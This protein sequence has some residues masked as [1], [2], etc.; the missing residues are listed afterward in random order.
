ML[1]MIFC[2]MIVWLYGFCCMINSTVF[3]W[4]VSCRLPLLLAAPS[5]HRARPTASF[6]T[7]I[8]N[9]RNGD[10]LMIT[11]CKNLR[12]ERAMRWETAAALSEKRSVSWK[13]P[14]H[15]S[16]E[17]TMKGETQKM[18]D[19][20]TVMMKTPDGVGRQARLSRRVPLVQ[21]QHVGR[22]VASSHRSRARFQAQDT[23]KVGLHRPDC[24]RIS[25][26]VRPGARC[27]G[28]RPCVGST[29][30]RRGGWWG[31]R[32]WGCWWNTK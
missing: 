10:Q 16:T 32:R 3:H 11:I 23:E 12:N 9:K 26:V 17:T 19:E 24:T 25:G 6:S 20:L 21:L 15:R 14:L 30:G 18:R 31:G 7:L 27:C 28:L 4:T 13:I 5:L 29:T 22:N 8:K 2:Y 1:L